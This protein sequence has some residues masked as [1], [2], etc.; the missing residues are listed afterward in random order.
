MSLL[1]M[2]QLLEEFEVTWC[3]YYLTGGQTLH[4]ADVVEDGGNGPL[5]K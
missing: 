4:D 5:D 1:G 3:Y 2:L